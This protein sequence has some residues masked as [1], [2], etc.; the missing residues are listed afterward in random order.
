MREQIY[1]YLSNNAGITA[2]VG[3][4]IFP[5]RVPTG[6]AL[7]YLQFTFESRDPSYDQDGYDDFNFQQINFNCAGSTLKEASDLSNALF[8]AMDVQF[9][10]IGPGGNTVYLNSTTLLSD[11]DD[12]D[13]FDGSEDGVRIVTQTYRL[14]YKE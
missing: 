14:T 4:R 11:F 13:L 12:F 10:D 5:Q 6:D 3:D 8:N 1:N 9:I 2:I 7:P